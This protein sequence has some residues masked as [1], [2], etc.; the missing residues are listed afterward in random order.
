MCWITG[1]L[2]FVLRDA[3][4]LYKLFQMFFSLR[5]FVKSFF[6]SGWLSLTR[7]IIVLSPSPSTYSTCV[8]LSR[9]S[10]GP[11]C[12]LTFFFYLSRA[13]SL[14]S[15]LPYKVCS[16]VPITCSI[17]RCLMMDCIIFIS[18]WGL[19]HKKVR[20]KNRKKL[21]S[22][23][24]KIVKAFD[25]KTYSPSPLTHISSQIKMKTKLFQSN[26]SVQTLLVRSQQK[27]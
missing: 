17:R 14:F 26:L 27:F 15:W 20:A 9:S 13:P 8:P 11:S 6:S 16:Y 23:N 22:Q 18:I 3:C 25:T 19:W 12:Q 10:F 21:I 1:L 4:S 24:S 2:I 5:G 7:A